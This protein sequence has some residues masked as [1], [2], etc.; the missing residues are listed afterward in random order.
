MEPG[1]LERGTRL[2]KQ[3]GR[4][5]RQRALV[6][7]QAAAE[8]KQ[9]KADRFHMKAFDRASKLIDRFDKDGQRRSV[10]TLREALAQ[11]LQAFER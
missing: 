6:G 9:L 8:S 2:V 11:L 3:A 1:G 7:S 10:R 4:G 5:V